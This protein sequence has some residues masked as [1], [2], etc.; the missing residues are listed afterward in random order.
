M[1]VEPSTAL[2]GYL[3]TAVEAQGGQRLCPPGV[4]ARKAVQGPDSS[5]FVTDVCLEA[6]NRT[7][8]S[9]AT[10]PSFGTSIAE[11]RTAG[12]EA[13]IRTVLPN[14]LKSPT[15][16]SASQRW[17][18]RLVRRAI[19]AS[20]QTTS[21]KVA[22]ETLRE[23][24]RAVLAQLDAT[25]T[26]ILDDLKNEL[27]ELLSRS[28][29]RGRRRT[30]APVDIDDLDLSRRGVDPDAALYCADLVRVLFCHSPDRPTTSE[31]LCSFVAPSARSYSIPIHRQASPPPDFLV[32]SG[33]A[34][35]RRL[36]ADRP[37]SKQRRFSSPKSSKR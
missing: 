16:S 31:T 35:I 4:L 25:E 5:P 23:G 19:Q 32:S 30:P 29:P 13:V 22:V 24:L 28:S 21:D 15:S 12:L 27:R 18:V 1:P 10:S 11:E 6:V 9:D 34:Q 37:P 8:A 33:T 17:L 26:G 7:L 14:V 2:R 36:S 20:K 3:A